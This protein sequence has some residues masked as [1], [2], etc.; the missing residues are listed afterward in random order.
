[1]LFGLY[2]DIGDR[3]TNVGSLTTDESIYIEIEF[4]L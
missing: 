1:M 3:V 2:D 4:L